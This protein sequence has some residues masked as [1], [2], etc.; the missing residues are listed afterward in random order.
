MEPIEKM[1]GG[2][3]KIPVPELNGQIATVLIKR[4]S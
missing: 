4:G 3:R 2:R 1:R